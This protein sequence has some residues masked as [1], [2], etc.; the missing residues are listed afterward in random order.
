MKLSVTRLTLAL[1]AVALIGLA[2]I[3]ITLN[4]QMSDKSEWSVLQGIEFAGRE[5]TDGSKVVFAASQGYDAIGI[6]ADSMPSIYPAPKTPRVWL[7]VDA[8][9]G[10][11]LKKIPP[12]ANYTITS[13]D[14]ETILRR[15]P[16]ISSAS[17][18]ELRQHIGVR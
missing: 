12:E 2:A 11:M 3:F 5:S 8:K 10:Q 16:N 9:Y 6:R 4:R 17:R 18:S 13:S 1:I 14:F 7:L 15:F